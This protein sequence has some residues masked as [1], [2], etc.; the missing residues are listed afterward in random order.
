MR[1]AR[2]KIIGVELL[3]LCLQNIRQPRLQM[4][5]TRERSEEKLP[6]A[7]VRSDLQDAA[8]W[9]LVGQEVKQIEGSKLVSRQF[10]KQRLA[11]W[12]VGRAPDPSFTAIV[13]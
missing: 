5:A 13:F 9:K 6:A 8:I 4:L 2:C 3:S 10:R 11:L 1:H 12:A 7:S